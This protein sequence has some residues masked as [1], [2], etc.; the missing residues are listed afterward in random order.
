[1]KKQLLFPMEERYQEFLLDESKFTGFAESISF[2]ETEQDVLE[3][4][5]E[6]RKRRENITIQGGKTGITGGA[7]PQG[8]HILNLSKMN[9][10]KGYQLS[11]DKTFCFITVEPGIT[12][13]ELKKEISRIPSAKPLFW[14]PEPTEASA[15]V[16]G[17]AATNA[18]GI[19]GYYYGNTSQYI[20]G[21]HRI[22]KRDQENGIEKIKRGEKWISIG[23]KEEDFLDL[24][25][26][27]EG[28][29]GIFTE[30]TLV[31]IPK[32][33]QVWGIGFFFEQEEDAAAFADELWSNIPKA[34]TAGV[35][36]M[37]YFDRNTMDMIE[38]RK[39]MM[40][41]LRE[42]P[43][44]DS[45]F[46]AMIY[47]ELHGSE[48]G[49]EELAGELMESAE[50][51]H[52]D[53]DK[54]WAVS[55]ETE[56]EKMRAFRHAAA[57][58]ANLRI[59]EIRQKNKNICKMGTDY[60]LKNKNISQTIKKIKKDIETVSISFCIFGHIQGN[61][62]HVN[63]FPE[64]EGEKEKGK[65]LLRKWAEETY[66][67][68]GQVIGEHGIGKLKKEMIPQR[69][70]QDKIDKIRLLQKDLADEIIWNQGNLWDG[71]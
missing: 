47:V 58:I 4:V 70:L 48:D 27:S 10:V 29:A 12:L 24:L 7:V 54:A 45:N 19:S 41:K 46:M 65:K 28:M 13:T 67:Y 68:N 44:I 55:G 30:L 23:G 42:I 36:A 40:T 5:K 14:P 2:P 57:E 50:I 37:E 26:G 39:A 3:I 62:L 8:G 15:T 32:P 63:L 6:M 60:S 59:E 43:D 16:G 34:E 21:L 53:S 38:K 61:H 66:L 33:E 52:S 35:A 22:G 69:L 25:I 49:I 71:E 51:F 11:E 64:T 1:M 18:Q 9:H 56:I 20:D 17:V 31:L